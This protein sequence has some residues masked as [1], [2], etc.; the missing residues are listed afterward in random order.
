MI[1]VALHLKPGQSVLILKDFPVFNYK[2]IVFKS[3]T[4]VLESQTN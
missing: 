4:V 2:V 3:Q 1:G